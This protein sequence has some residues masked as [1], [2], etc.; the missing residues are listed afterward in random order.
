MPVNL[1]ANLV[2]DF[3]SK[4]IPIM[5]TNAS[6]YGFSFAMPQGWKQRWNGKYTCG[7]R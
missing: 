6:K 5:I 7:C 3:C 1:W 2:C 4:S